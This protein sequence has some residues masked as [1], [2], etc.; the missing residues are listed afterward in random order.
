MNYPQNLKLICN[1]YL[2]LINAKF[3][4]IRVPVIQVSNAPFWTVVLL[5][6]LQMHLFLMSDQE[7]LIKVSHV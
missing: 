7:S 2:P 5:T 1:A 3:L 6:L 4:Q